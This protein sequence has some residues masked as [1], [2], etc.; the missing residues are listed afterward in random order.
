MRFA[1]F[2]LLLLPLLPAPLGGQEVQRFGVSQ[3]QQVGADPP[4]IKAYLDVLGAEGEAVSD[5]APAD[6]AAVL[7]EGSL[8]VQRFEP[9]AA[10]GEGVA[11]VFLVDVSKSLSSEQFGQIQEVLAD[12]LSALGGEDR[13]A[14]L[15]FGDDSRLVADFTADRAALAA[16]LRT[17]APTD[18]RT[19]LYRALDHAL[20]LGQRQ[21]PGLPGRRVQVV[22]SDGRDEGSGRTLEDVLGRLRTEPMPIY[23]I[24]HSQLPAAVRQRYLDILH[25]LA[26][27]SGGAFV[28]AAEGQIAE[29]RAAIEG[30]L[31]RVWVA[32]M[33]CASCKADGSVYRLQLQLARGSQRL[34]AGT[35][36][37]LLPQPVLARGTAAEEPPP[38]PASDGRR[39]DEPR[40]DGSA[41]AMPPLSLPGGILRFWPYLA[42][43]A[44]ALA[45][46]LVLWRR[47]R[48]REAPPQ[49]AAGAG[50]AAELEEFELP[51]PPV[52][53][54]E[55]PAPPKAIKLVVIR[56]SQ[57]GTEYSL[58]LRRQAV[59]GQEASCDCVLD[60]EPGIS[61]QQ[62]ELSQES[63]LVFLRNLAPDNP[64]LV[65]GVPV[66]GPKEIT[67]GDLVGTRHTI[68]RVV[69]PHG[70]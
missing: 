12:W 56:G 40:Q 35:E 41:G 38:P 65:G 51:L 34:A 62:F 27:N 18:S 53:A 47:G 17:L 59:V 60:Q 46:G 63:G 39:Q 61:P 37:R 66:S 22:L 45:L 33:A 9:F 43:A 24:G 8:T 30:A 1:T 21:D 5:L 31:R 26:S 4:V 15:A 57:R 10:S 52:T 48:R 13:A 23:A 49:A 20:D 28:L 6:L 70:P 55:A 50:A 16:A 32:T 42:G 67:D 11:Y 29:A 54:A 36:M 58:V 14:I 3:V 69:L 25:R 64:T 19:V 7:G 68:L 44:L 2:S